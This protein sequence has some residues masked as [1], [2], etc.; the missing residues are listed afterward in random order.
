MSEE[1]ELESRAEKIVIERGD[2]L[3]KK[4]GAETVGVG[5]K[6]INGE[7]TNQIAIIFFVKNKAVALQNEELQEIPDNIDGIPTDVID[8]SS[9]FKP[10]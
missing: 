2:E 3:I 6:Q 9:G 7:I 5:L 8:M 1:D 10:T 4:Y